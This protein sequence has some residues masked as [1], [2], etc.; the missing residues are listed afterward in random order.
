MF[1]ACCSA[2]LH[3]APVHDCCQQLSTAAVAGKCCGLAH[4]RWTEHQPR[5]PGKAASTLYWYPG[6]QSIH[7]HGSGNLGA[8]W[9]MSRHVLLQLRQLTMSFSNDI[10]VGL[11]LSQEQKEALAITFQGFTTNLY[12]LTV[13]CCAL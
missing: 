9:Q 4:L 8:D 10:V 12:C 13:R 2:C 1:S 5:I 6:W 11:G 7:S 3:L